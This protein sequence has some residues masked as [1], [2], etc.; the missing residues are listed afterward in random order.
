MLLQEPNC[1]LHPQVTVFCVC[2]LLSYYKHPHLRLAIEN[3]IMQGTIKL[4]IAAVAS[5][6]TDNI[7]WP[8]PPR[9]RK[10]QHTRTTT[11]TQ[12]N[13]ISKA[14]NLLISSDGQSTWSRIISIAGIQPWEAHPASK[15]NSA[16]T[17]KQ[18]PQ[19]PA[20]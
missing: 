4:T 1:C 17:P 6:C 5:Q 13:A 2:P 16:Y 18:E 12:A 15:P 8:L 7:T 10:K 9:K 3:R 19:T 20:T 14:Q 11:S